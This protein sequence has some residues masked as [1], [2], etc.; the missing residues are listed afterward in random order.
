[1]RAYVGGWWEVNSQ[2]EVQYCIVRE[3]E[4]VKEEG[5]VGVGEGEIRRERIEIFGREEGRVR[6]I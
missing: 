3:K 4:E 1:M 6:E 5:N 2:E